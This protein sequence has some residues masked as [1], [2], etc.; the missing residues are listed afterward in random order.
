MLTGCKGGFIVW[1]RLTEIRHE[2]NHDI[3]WK[4]KN[5]SMNFWMD[6]WTKMEPSIT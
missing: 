4:L 6:N 3:W 1:K 5:G 2:V